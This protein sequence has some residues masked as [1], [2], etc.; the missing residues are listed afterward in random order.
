MRS[1]YPMLFKS[2]QDFNKPLYLA[3][4]TAGAAVSYA[5]PL[6]FY[7]FLVPVKKKAQGFCQS[8]VLKSLFNSVGRV[9][10]W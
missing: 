3:A 1:L 10:A 4:H 9:F 5:Q 2:L 7:E 8:F 6:F